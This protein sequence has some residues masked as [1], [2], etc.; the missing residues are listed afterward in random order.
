MHCD[1]IRA[2]LIP[3]LE[4]YKWYPTKLIDWNGLTFDFNRKCVSIKADR[5]LDIKSLLKTF[6]HKWPN[7]SYREY[8]KL[9]GTLISMYPVLN[10]LEP[11]YTRQF[12]N[13]YKYMTF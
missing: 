4:K 13:F 10:G 3:G 2:G 12:T 5:I 11:L 6:L 8:S 9:S 1:L 7:V